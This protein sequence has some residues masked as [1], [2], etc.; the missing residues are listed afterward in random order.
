[1]ENKNKI[2][3]LILGLI[4]VVALVFFGTKA[5]NK[6]KGEAPEV[7]N[8]NQPKEELGKPQA[9]PKGQVTENFPE[10][11]LLDKTATLESSY[12]IPYGEGRQYTVNQTTSK[13]VE[14]EYKVYLDYLT[15][16]KYTIVNKDVKPTLGFI[17]A[18]KGNNDVNVQI[19]PAGQG[20]TQITISYLS[21]K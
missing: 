13:S 1:M 20:K 21:K 9:A 16:E 12:Q 14:D 19:T 17:Y 5:I 4:V 18:T 7:S 8:N 15:N 11:L 2:I 3:G 10:P 6:E